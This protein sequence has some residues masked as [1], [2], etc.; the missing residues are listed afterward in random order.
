MATTG[1]ILPED[2]LIATLH[3]VGRDVRLVDDHTL[4][5]IFDEAAK[6]SGS[7]F[8]PFQSHPLYGYSRLLGES[9]QTLDNA[10]S[11]VREN[12][13]QHRFRASEHTAGPFGRN[14]YNAMLS[15]QQAAIDAVA[16]KIR[17][18]FGSV[19]DAGKCDVVS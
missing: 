12:A 1:T 16:Q 13:S 15:K 4:S 11:I 6:E 2:V 14:L 9:L 3:R 8:A 19:N 17:Q 7:L 5:E 10:G 18:A